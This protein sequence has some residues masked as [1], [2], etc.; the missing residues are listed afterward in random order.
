LNAPWLAI[1]LFPLGARID[2]HFQLRD[3]D[4]SI[5]HLNRNWAISSN[6][7]PTG[8][9]SG[10][11]LVKKF[12]LVIRKRVG[13]N[14][15]DERRGRALFE[16]ISLQAQRWRY[17]RG[18]QDWFSIVETSSCARGEIAVITGGN[19]HGNYSLPDAIKVDANVCSARCC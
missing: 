15:F 13:A 19:V 12:L 11:R 17:R 5:T 3:V 16:L 10:A 2:L 7:S 8:S 18:R 14:P 6:D 9:T 1:N 4:W